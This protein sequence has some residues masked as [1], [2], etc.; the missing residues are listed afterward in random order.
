MIPDFIDLGN[1]APWQV[2]PPGIHIVTLKEIESSFGN[3]TP[4]RQNLFNG[5]CAALKNLEQAGCRTVYLD[6]SFVSDKD[7]P[8]DFDA[9]WDHKGVDPNKLDPTLLDFSNKRE[10]Q[11]I[12]YG[13]ELFIAAALAAPG[14][15]FLKYF[16]TDRYTGK[17][18]GILQINLTGKTFP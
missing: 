1:P 5:L 2:L 8:G 14:I 7:H 18:K 12:Q 13:G 3:N 10:A 9:C 15:S 6:G 16:Q 4:H 11:K 17:K